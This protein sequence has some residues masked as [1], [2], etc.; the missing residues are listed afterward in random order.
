MPTF[1]KKL[2]LLTSLTLILH[3]GA[4][5][6]IEITKPIEEYSFN[7][8]TV[9]TNA[10]G[11]PYKYAEWHSLFATGKYKLKPVHEE[12]DSTA[13]ILTLRNEKTEHKDFAAL[14]PTPASFFKKGNSFLLLTMEDA[15]GNKIAA[16][17]L[18]G[19]I[20]VV[21]FWFIACPPCR[22]EMPELNRIVDSYKNSSDIVFLAITFDK[23]EDVKRFLK[24]SPFKYKVIPESMPLFSYYGV[25]SCP[26][27]IVV[28]KT[29]VIVFNSLGYN[30]GSVPFWI[31]KTIKQLKA[32]K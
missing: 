2:L 16:E 3:F 5:S 15:N 20:V 22:Y 14:T 29:G 23:K 26:A 7:K 25:D 19:K 1:Y 18:K 24:V 27:S 17:D 21:N 10:G 6:Q 31:D 32:Q 4:L 28:D 13:F 8:N 12:S 11:V 9:V 30:E